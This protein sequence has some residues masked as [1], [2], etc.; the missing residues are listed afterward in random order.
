[1]TSES[2]GTSTTNITAMKASS[3]EF[4]PSKQTSKTITSSMTASHR[5]SYS[6]RIVSKPGY[7][8]STLDINISSS[9]SAIKLWMQIPLIIV[10]YSGSKLL[11]EI[12]SAPNLFSTTIE[13]LLRVKS[14]DTWRKSRSRWIEWRWWTI[15]GLSV[16]SSAFQSPA[17]TFPTMSTSTEP[18]STQYSSKKQSLS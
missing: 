15:W 10:C 8:R 16:M 2:F 6:A 3:W 9:T 18:N 5:K 14:M 11:L 4:T 1:M 17:K 7:D 12:F 13:S